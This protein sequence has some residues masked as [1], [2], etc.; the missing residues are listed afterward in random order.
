MRLLN[1]DTFSFTEYFGTT[2]PPYAIASH[3]WTAGAE[4]MWEDVHER[5]RTDT[6]GYR[7]VQGFVAYIR[8]YLPLVKWL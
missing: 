2:P 5:K 3:R 7:K 8:T 1:V 6:S 4:A